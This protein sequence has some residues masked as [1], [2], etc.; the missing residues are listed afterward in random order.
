M[1]FLQKCL[2]RGGNFVYRPKQNCYNSHNV[3]Q[4]AIVQCRKYLYHGLASGE[5][6]YTIYRENTELST[7]YDPIFY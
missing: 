2:E 3:D 6:K 5:R 4:Q 7:F 1:W